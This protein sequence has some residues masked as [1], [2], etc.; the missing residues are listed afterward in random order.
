VDDERELE[1]IRE[2]MAETRTALAD[3]IEALESQVRDTVQSATDTVS[4]A[5]EGAKDVVSSVTE[6]AK[7]VVEKVSETVE[8]VKESLSISNYVERYPWAS[9]GASVAAG[10][11]VAQLL[12]AWRSKSGDHDEALPP[13]SAGEYVAPR[14]SP[15]PSPSQEEGSALGS[16]LSGVWHQAAGTLEGL[17]VGT[18]MGAVKEL[19]SRS[20]PQDWQ[21][22]L[23]RMVDDVTNRLGGKVMHGNPLN[24]LLSAFQPKQDDNGQSH[25]ATN[26]NTARPV[27]QGARN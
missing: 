5:V 1:V 20:L 3:K 15:L 19:V 16:V 25:S 6:G 22:E 2:E 13:A 18:L 26:G 8:S 27:G 23:T 4:N 7:D 11:A 9:L 10:F 21:S 14:R 17:A 12:P 24:E